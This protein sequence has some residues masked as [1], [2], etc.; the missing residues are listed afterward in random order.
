MSS[1]S[2]K[3]NGI[4]YE[5]EGEGP[6][7]LLLHG[8]TLN[9]SIFRPLI[10]VLRETCRCIAIDLP[11]HGQSDPVEGEDADS[12]WIA[13]S[14]YALAQKL[15]V[16]PPLLVGH[17]FGAVVALAYATAFPSRGLITLDQPLQVMGFAQ[18]IQDAGAEGV[19]ALWEALRGTFGLEHFTPAQ[20][21][22]V[23]A[24]TGPV[25]PVVRQ[26]WYR[27]LKFSPDEVQ[28]EVEGWLAKI[29]GPFTAVHAVGIGDDYAAWL[30][31]R[32]GSAEIVTL[33]GATH[34]PQITFPA[35]ICGVIQAMQSSEASD[36]TS[37]IY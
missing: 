11:G 22:I 24:A 13:A 2:G 23:D 32:A 17:S 9:R 1:I 16:S 35:A 18:T 37:S 26:Y 20:R 3:I 8:L 6:A 31:S 7:I 30:Q 33:P 15:A 12:N 14:I 25:N 19:A 10:S 27:M 21:N 28:A 5:T 29:Q 4:A 34:F 36:P